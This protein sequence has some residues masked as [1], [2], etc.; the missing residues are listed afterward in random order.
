MTTPTTHS[1]YD[2]TQFRH[3]LGH[4]P[5]SVAIVTGMYRGRPVGVTIGSF[6]SVSLDPPLVNFFVDRSSRTWPQLNES[7]TFTVNVLGADQVHLC[8]AFSR[9]GVDRFESVAWKLSDA[10]NP[11]LEDAMVTLDCSLYKVDILGDHIQVVG[12][13]DAMQLRTV[14]LP[15]VFY[16]GDFVDF[17]AA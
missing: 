13:V 5:T 3:V 4:I 10:G 7:S 6:S 9:R 8:Q 12:R 2:A 16:R 1:P 11:V 15:L 14:G 17:S